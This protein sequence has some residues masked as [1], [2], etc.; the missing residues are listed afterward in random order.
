VSLLA[1]LFSFLFFFFL[2]VR[3]ARCDVMTALFALYLS[4]ANT[5]EIS[6]VTA[7]S[8]KVTGVSVTGEEGDMRVVGV[9][10][11]S[12]VLGGS[13][14]PYPPSHNQKPDPRAYFC[15]SA[16]VSKLPVTPTG[17]VR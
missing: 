6:S 12:A 9:T 16:V 17:G 10:P 5:H 8:V 2:V 4:P 1:S 7:I 3:V 15:Y 13:Y 11:I 14:G